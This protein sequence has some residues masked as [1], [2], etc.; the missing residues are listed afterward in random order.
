MPNAPHPKLLL[1][2]FLTLSIA[3]GCSSSLAGTDDGCGSAVLAGDLVITEAFA[4]A[5]SEDDGREWIEIYNATDTTTDLAG[6]TLQSSR[7]DGSASKQ[8]V[9]TTL[10]LERHS[11]AVVGGVVDDPAV[12]PEYV[13]YGYGADLGELRGTEGELIVACGSSVVDRVLYYD[14]TEA[15]SRSYDGA[16]VPDASGNDDLSAWCDGVT[17]FDAPS[18]GTPGATNEPCAGGAPTRCREDGVVRNA[19]TPAPGDV[20]I[21]EFLANPA[22]AS[23][24]DAE[25][26]EIYVRADVDLNGLAIGKAVDDAAVVIADLD[27]VRATAGSY[28]VFAKDED[29]ASNGGLPPVA[30]VFDLALANGSGALW[31]GVGGTELD[32]VTWTTAADGAASSLDPDFIDPAGNDD[33]GH[34]CAATTPYGDGDLGT[35]GTANDT[36][37]TIAPPAG[38]CLDGAVLVDVDSPAVGEL[39][40]SEFMSNP[41][42]VGDTAGE[43]FEITAGAPFHLNGLELGRASDTLSTIVEV[44]ECVRVD[45]GDRVVFAREP[46]PTENGGLPPAVFVFDFSLPNANGA[47]VVGYR[48]EVLDEVAWTS[49]SA[50]TATALDP[51]FSGPADNDDETHWCAAIAAYGDGDLG[52]PGVANSACA[53]AVPGIC[54]DGKSERI[55]VAP[56]LGDLVITEVMP[57]P[58]A[59]TDASGEWFEVL[60][61]ADVDLNGLEL[62]TEVDSVDVTLP[63]GGDCL[64]VAAGTRIV[65]ARSTASAENGA[66][67]QTFSAFDFGL[68]NGGG[69]LF[70][71]RGGMVLDEIS[72][73]AARAGVAISLDPGSED[74]VAN[75]D[76]G[77]FCP[78]TIPYGSGDL[79]TPAAVGLPCRGGVAEGMCDD[80][81]SL[82]SIVSPGAGDLVITEAMVNPATVPDA[83]G[84]WFEVLVNADV[85]LNGLQLYSSPD[86]VPNLEQT[87]DASS[88]LAIAAGTRVVFARTADE[89]SNGGV[90]EVDFVVTFALT[91]TNYGLA[92]GV[93]DDV[94]DAITWTTVASGSSYSLSPAATDP[95]TNNAAANWCDA[96]SLYG[97]GDRGTPAAANDGCP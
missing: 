66:I 51:S 36:Q 47:L 67:G 97:A 73:G 35:P 93:A 87:L 82:R 31:V 80:N 52:T 28:L 4:D 77:N 29:P 24:A 37:C 25:W 95:A 94:L 20:V 16:R 83:A 96:T 86:G 11:Y 46:D 50:G 39:W 33:P 57:D 49:S 91:N 89:V 75:D 27:C 45:V 55:V 44:A 64:A 17:V 30:G 79:G 90:S 48:G 12:R 62:G 6:I 13:D 71:G 26:V 14:G 59:V 22:A 60:V 3:L 8:H 10:T 76:H 2:I 43:W 21:T 38:R 9:V 53:G 84:E 81:G 85:D 70:V 88:C 78:A 41:G 72:W 19:L 92:V 58:A 18:R 7:A 69:N 1:G 63:A 23:D 34:F 65:F 40:I 42:A 61:G 56:A 32:T 15:A 5:P 68:T 74:T 54:T